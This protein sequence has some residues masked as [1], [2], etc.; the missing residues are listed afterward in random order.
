M[1]AT[2][3]ISETVASAP[4]RK[5]SLAVRLALGACGILLVSGVRFLVTANARTNKVVWLAQSDLQAGR[6]ETLKYTLMRW[7][8]PLWRGYWSRQPLVLVNSTMLATPAAFHTQFGLGLP[9]ETN[10]DGLQVWTLSA[11]EFKSLRQ[12]LETLPDEIKLGSPRVQTAAGVWSS[13]SMLNAGSGL[14][15]TLQAK[16][17]GNSWT[18][19]TG[20]IL[21]EPGQ[22]ASTNGLLLHTNF[23]AACRATIPNAGALVIQSANRIEAAGT[24]YWLIVSPV[25]IDAQGK[26]IQR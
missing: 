19:T 7:T 12:Q 18:L 1:K 26:P 20:A 5:L 14:T 9:A 21:T 25:A 17:H 15:V 16:T 8:A 23:A 22:S 3:I 4:R 13:V 10:A 6:F 24:N 11:A 2:P